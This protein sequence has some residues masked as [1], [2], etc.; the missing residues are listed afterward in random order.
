MEIFRLE[1]AIEGVGKENDVAAIST[2]PW[3][4]E[5]GPRLRAG[6]G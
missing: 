1:I 3:R 2:S 6:R 5:V 4:G